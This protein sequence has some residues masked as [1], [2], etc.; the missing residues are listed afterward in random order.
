L[1]NACAICAHSN[2]DVV[3]DHDRRRRGSFA[4]YEP[5]EG[6]AY[7]YPII[8]QNAMKSRF[9]PDHHSVDQGVILLDCYSRR[10]WPCH[11]PHSVTGRIA[12]RPRQANVVSAPVRFNRVVGA[13]LPHAIRLTEQPDENR[14][15]DESTNV[16]PVGDSTGCGV[17]QGS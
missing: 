1:N 6:A 12:R 7:D 2:P 8:D 9:G 17:R 13:H 4:A 16:R 11:T 3:A 10:R 14:S 15:G 5:L